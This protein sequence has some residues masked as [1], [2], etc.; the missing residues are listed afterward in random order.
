MCYNA[1]GLATLQSLMNWLSIHGGLIPHRG[2]TESF[3]LMTLRRSTLLAF[4]QLPAG[5]PSI[6]EK[7]HSGLIKCLITLS[8][9]LF[10]SKEWTAA[11]NHQSDIP[12][13]RSQTGSAHSKTQTHTQSERTSC[14][15]AIKCLY[16]LKED[17]LFETFCRGNATMTAKCNI[18]R[19]MHTKTA[20]KSKTIF[21]FNH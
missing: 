5:G 2:K 7:I 15:Q 6:S 16:N 17:T 12:A 1:V 21:P 11:I 4:M 9:H 13:I 8:W 20:K 10:Q 14:S 18:M 19:W 3:F